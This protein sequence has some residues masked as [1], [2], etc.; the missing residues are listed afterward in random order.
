ME[1][2]EIGMAHTGTKKFKTW[3][4]L[5]WVTAIGI[6]LMP[7]IGMQ[8]TDEIQW[9]GEDFM[10]MGG[11]LLALLLAFEFIQQR[12]RGRIAIIAGL[13]VVAAFLLV[14]AELAV[15]LFDQL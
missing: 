9:G 2:V 4:I 15:G 5:R 8:F 14:W 11:M 12:I 7:L 10:A 13:V 1:L 3:R 6:L